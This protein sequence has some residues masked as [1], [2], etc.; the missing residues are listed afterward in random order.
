MC[1][2]LDLSAALPD[3]AYK[4]D[5]SRPDLFNRAFQQWCQFYGCLSV[6]GEPRPVLEDFCDAAEEEGGEADEGE[7][8][9]RA[10]HA[11]LLKQEIWDAQ[12]EKAVLCLGKCTTP[13]IYALLQGSGPD[14]HYASLM[15]AILYELFPDGA[16]KR[17][18]YTL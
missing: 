2:G 9:A 1:E 14:S 17:D 15:L 8:G 5:G 7:N 12:N 10:A 11:Q 16:R 13:E 4:F 18:D 6:L 3:Y